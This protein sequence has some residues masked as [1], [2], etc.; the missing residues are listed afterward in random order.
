MVTTL[1]VLSMETLWYFV[2]LCVLLSLQGRSCR[3][4]QVVYHCTFESNE[5]CKIEQDPS[6]DFDWEVHRGLAPINHQRRLRHLRRKRGSIRAESWPGPMGL[7]QVP[8]PVD[9]WDADN[10]NIF[11]D[12]PPKM[13]PGRHFVDHT[14]GNQSGHFAHLVAAKNGR[15]SGHA[16]IMSP[17][18]TIPDSLEADLKF[19]YH[20]WN[21][22]ENPTAGTLKVFACQQQDLVFK[23]STSAGSVWMEAEIRIQCNGTFR[24]IFEGF[25]SGTDTDIAIDDVNVTV[26]DF[27]FFKP[28]ITW[29][30][31]DSSDEAKATIMATKAPSLTKGDAGTP[32]DPGLGPDSPGT[33]MDPQT[34]VSLV[35]IAL[36]LFAA[37]CFM[38]LITLMIHIRIRSKRRRR[39]RF[40][41]PFIYGSEF[42][43]RHSI[44]PSEPTAYMTLNFPPSST[45]GSAAEFFSLSERTTYGS[46]RSKPSSGFHSKR[47][48]TGTGLQASAESIRRSVYTRRSTTGQRRQSRTFPV[49][50][51]LKNILETVH[52]RRIRTLSQHLSVADVET[53]RRT[54]CSQGETANNSDR[55]LSTVLL[56]TTASTIRPG[57]SLSDHFYY[58]LFPAVGIVSCK[59]SLVA[60]EESGVE[61]MD[62]SR[63][64][65]SGDYDSDDLEVQAVTSGALLDHSGS[66]HSEHGS[67]DL[68]APDTTMMVDNEIYEC[69]SNSDSSNSNSPLIAD[70]KHLRQF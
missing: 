44:D 41:E 34:A 29:D 37:T 27:P 51:E 69:Y 3:A 7:I 13:Q 49:M 30:N 35:V 11:L 12:L 5:D 15:T 21:A 18:I 9:E 64:A 63:S 66:T 25:I 32:I 28:N 22:Q 36:V 8:D 39:G 1:S 20:L 17:P 60:C 62:D 26:C 50:K 16:R 53:L 24:I 38:L 68:E 52:M 58:S 2:L 31:N 54:L 55:T 45:S 47:S 61:E 65:G 14:Y 19:F 42:F 59:N 23:A 57:S 10:G 46:K 48:S 6:D 70:L 40:H 4:S 56:D 33:G 43:N 67:H